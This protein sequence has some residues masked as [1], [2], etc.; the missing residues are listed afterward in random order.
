MP[1]HPDPEAAQ[2]EYEE[3]RRAVLEG[4]AD[5]DAHSADDP[6]P[7]SAWV[8]GRKLME[9]VGD[10]PRVLA[11]LGLA[12]ARWAAIEAR[13]LG[14]LH[15]PSLRARHDLLAER[16]D[17]REEAARV[18]ASPAPVTRGPLAPA[19]GSVIARGSRLYVAREGRLD[20][21]ELASG[22]LL[23]A[24]ALPA[25]PAQGEEGR[26]ALFDPV[27]AGEPGAVLVRTQAG[28]LA[29]YD[30]DTGAPR[31]QVPVDPYHA[32][33]EEVP[34]LGV[35]VHTRGPTGSW[36]AVL[37]A[38]TGATVASFGGPTEQI[39]AVAVHGARLLLLVAQGGAPGAPPAP[40]L[41]WGPPA[42]GPPIPAGMPVVAGVVCVDA[43]T[44]Q[45]ARPMVPARAQARP[46]PAVL[47][48]R[49]LWAGASPGVLL[50]IA[51]GP[52]PGVMGRLIGRRDDACLELALPEPNLL[53]D[54]LR[55]AGPVIAALVRPRGE[56]SVRLLAVD[57]A[58]P[59]IVADTGDLGPAPHRPSGA[60]LVTSGPLAVLATG[61]TA[62]QPATLWG[63]DAPSGRRRWS[64]MIHGWTG[65]DFVGDHLVA[66]TGEGAVA[67]R[68]EDG[69]MLGAWPP[70][71]A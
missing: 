70:A 12:P 29:A 34:G 31:W 42:A 18:A 62:D 63:I 38:R 44:G 17:V 6:L 3:T 69:A 22:R 36:A 25:P 45:R 50:S 57:P 11:H 9:A 66:W 8:R 58:A 51:I 35:V 48:E 67:L 33:I 56:S 10:A 19:R 41:P 64:A 21:V 60:G 43:R 16:L 54:A 59:A 37:D 39:E 7:M 52:A 55:P 15:L 32:T 13:W 49:S 61:T 20:A 14:L 28:A 24:A 2:R 47:G 30:R 46:A 40:P 5:P 68:P 53:V 1:L 23:W 71:G 27:S 4:R 26:A 65:H